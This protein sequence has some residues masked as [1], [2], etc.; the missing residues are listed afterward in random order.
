MEPLS[1]T[2]A[3]QHGLHDLRVTGMTC[4]HCARAIEKALSAVAGVTRTEVS[5]AA[6]SA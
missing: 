2:R 6:G 4:D 1:A 5:Y 3:K